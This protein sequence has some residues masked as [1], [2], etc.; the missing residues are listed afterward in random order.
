MG[1]VLFVTGTDTGVGKTLLTCLL[2][3]HLRDS[4]V[5]ALAV[6]PFCT[7]NLQDAERL[8]EQQ[9]S[10]LSLGEITPF[11]Y[12]PAVAPLVAARRLSQVVGL[13]QVM[14]QVTALRQRCEVL[15][16]EGCGGLLV[17]L[18]ESFSVLELIQRL[19]CPV[20]LVAPNRLGTLNH[21]LLSLRAMKISGPQVPTVVLMGVKEQDASQKDNA[22]II[23]EFGGPT[24][25][26]ALPFLGGNVFA[27]RS[28]AK[29]CKQLKKPLAEILRKGSLIPLA[30]NN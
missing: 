16:V 28:I 10:A 23:E 2:L 8:R 26:I 20:I 27:K 11:F 14:A 1:R 21:T 5:N 12:E 15:L 3:R 9:A 7:G 13:E 22:G 19:C 24:R 17:P 29:C 6:K 30:A 25:V 18:G 4:G